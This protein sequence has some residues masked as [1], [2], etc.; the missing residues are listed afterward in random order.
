M[1]AAAAQKTVR[2]K[3]SE[4]RK[5]PEKS[6]MDEVKEAVASEWPIAGSDD[7]VDFYDMWERDGRHRIRINWWKR[8]EDGGGAIYFSRLI[9]AWRD[10]ATKLVIIKD[11]T[12]V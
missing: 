4:T 9:H 2:E 5:A 7:K 1:A 12:L 8:H 10:E 3:V 6:F 11:V